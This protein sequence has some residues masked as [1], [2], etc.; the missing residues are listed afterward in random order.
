[1]NLNIQNSVDSVNV[2]DFHWPLQISGK[3]QHF[4]KSIRGHL[5]IVMGKILR[6]PQTQ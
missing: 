1:M 4:I 3:L 6:L 5:E 2:Q